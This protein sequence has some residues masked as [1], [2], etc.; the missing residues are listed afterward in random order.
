MNGLL[1]CF[2]THAQSSKRKYFVS[3]SKL[4]KNKKKHCKL[5]R[6]LYRK[7]L[8]I[9]YYTVWILVLIRY[10]DGKKML[11]PFCHFY[12]QL[13]LMGYFRASA[14]NIAIYQK[15][16]Y[17]IW[18]VILCTSPTRTYIKKMWLSLQNELIEITWPKSVMNL[19]QLLK[20]FHVIYFGKS[21]FKVVM[22][23]DIQVL[24]FSC[25]NC[26]T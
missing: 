7:P 13:P 6:F 26:V 16:I 20:I 21:R 17:I 18:A 4:Q 2:Y 15:K 25:Q 10:I 8:Y 19:R 11:H 22:K 5:C 12:I 14:A 1:F 24:S 9:L 23:V 3:Y